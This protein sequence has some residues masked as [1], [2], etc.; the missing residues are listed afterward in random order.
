[1]VWLNSIIALGILIALVVSWT[2]WSA[3]FMR[4]RNGKPLLAAEPR[5]QVPWRAV[6]IAI[7]LALLIGLPLSAVLGLRAATDLLPT[8]TPD[9]ISSD[10]HAALLAATSLASLAVLAL[11]A[12]LVMLRAGATWRDLGVSPRHVPADLL[13]GVAAFFMLAPAVYLVMLVLVQWFPSEHPIVKLVKDDPRLFAL[14]FF[15]AVCV[16]PIVEEFLF[17]VLFQGWL[18]RVAGKLARQSVVAAAAQAPATPPE[19]ADQMPLAPRRDD[20]N[21]YA[22]PLADLP[23]QPL[24]V[25]SAV[26]RDS[27]TSPPPFWPVLV[28]SSIFALLHWG[29]GPDPVP[30]F[31]LAVGLGYLYRQTHRVLPGIVVHVLLNAF[32]MLVLWLNVYGGL[33]K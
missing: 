1:M 4:L 17:R 11:A 33:G 24:T 28:S 3:A 21:P 30:L 6:D 9:D 5:R 25:E 27:S 14:S 20:A 13:L 19:A 18:E 31:V 10:G 29:H 26:N 23:E 32:S 15:S 7:C 22:P 2:L 16:A 12:L 8:L